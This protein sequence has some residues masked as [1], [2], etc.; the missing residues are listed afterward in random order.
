MRKEGDARIMVPGRCE[1]RP[2]AS[3]FEWGTRHDLEF[4]PARNRRSRRR[5][6]GSGYQAAW[7]AGPAASMVQQ[8]FQLAWHPSYT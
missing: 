8:L 4:Q 3:A 5:H 7:K 1:R 2:Q 6:S